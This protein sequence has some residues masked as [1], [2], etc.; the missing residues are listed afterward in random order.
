MSLSL[1]CAVVLSSCC[2]GAQLMRDARAAAG[3][4]KKVV[5][6]VVDVKKEVRHFLKVTAM[7]RM[8][9]HR[10]SLA[11][12]MFSSFA[13]TPMPPMQVEKVVE[14]EVEKVVEVEKLVEVEVEREVEVV[15][16]VELEKVRLVKLSRSDW[17]ARLST[18]AL[19]SPCGG[20]AP[21]SCVAAQTCHLHFRPWRSSR[22]FSWR[23]FLIWQVVEVEQIIKVEKEV[24]VRQDE[25]DRI[26][27]ELISQVCE[28]TPRE[29]ESRAGSPREI[30]PFGGS[31]RRSARRGTC[32]TSR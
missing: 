16:E 24:G 2:G 15:R 21:R 29:I 19:A 10:L 14:V 23:T 1:R 3:I 18:P 5:E 30:E 20:R 28:T 4:D 22:A 17:A 32:S 9:C 25:V 11:H 6:R 12:T 13:H 27:R 8:R 7:R 31:R 26:Q